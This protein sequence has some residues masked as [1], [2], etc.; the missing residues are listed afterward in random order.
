MEAVNAI[1]PSPPEPGQGV[2]SLMNE[3]GEV[4]VVDPIGSS[5]ITSSAALTNS[6]NHQV[7]ST[8]LP[9]VVWEWYL[10]QAEK[11]KR[12][13][14]CSSLEDNCW[15]LRTS[16]FN[17]NAIVKIFCV[18]C[19]KEIGRDSRKHDKVNIQN[20]F[21]N[22]KSKHLLNTNHVKNWCAHNDV[23]YT[24]HLQYVAS[25]GEAIPLTPE[26]H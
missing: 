24:N 7:N 22:F 12:D 15:F 18:E 14:K 9:N 6:L 8:L 17:G 19:H 11:I 10:K 3:R 2:F 21:N 1:V 20:L 25:K 5:R 4:H 23:L 16:N 26:L 13:L